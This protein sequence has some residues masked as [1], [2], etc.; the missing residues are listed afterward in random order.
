MTCNVRILILFWAILSIYVGACILYS[1]AFWF[2]NNMLLYG[3][4]K[5]VPFHVSI[6]LMIGLG[7]ANLGWTVEQRRQRMAP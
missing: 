2:Y 7:T 1:N 5:K 3:E 4:K 6:E